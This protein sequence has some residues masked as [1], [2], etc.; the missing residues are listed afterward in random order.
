M[1]EDVFGQVTDTDSALPSHPLQATNNTAEVAYW[2]ALTKVG[3]IYRLDKHLFV[4]QDWNSSSEMLQV[5]LPLMLEP[6]L[7]VYLVDWYLLPC[8]M[9]APECRRVWS[10]VYMPSLE[11]TTRVYPPTNYY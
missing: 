6:I 10:C 1:L 4:F 7:T 5:V 2:H 3:A 8:C 11:G 9:L